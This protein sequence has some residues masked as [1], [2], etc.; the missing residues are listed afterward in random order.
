MDPMGIPPFYTGMS[1]KATRDPN[2]HQNGSHPW[3]TDLTLWAVTS[4]LT[5]SLLSP[6]DKKGTDLDL[7]KPSKFTQIQ[8][9]LAVW[10]QR[11]E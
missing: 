3:D 8:N 6:T 2:L 10:A 11:E 1:G 7:A 9:Q 5:C 4:R